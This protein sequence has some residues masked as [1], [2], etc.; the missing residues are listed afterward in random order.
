MK[1][2]LLPIFLLFA[3]CKVSAQ[4]S[5]VKQ[6]ENIYYIMNQNNQY[7]GTIN[8]T[9]NSQIIG[10]NSKIVIV[11]VNSNITVYNSLGYIVSTR[12]FDTT[13]TLNSISN[14]GF[15]LNTLKGSIEFDLNFNE[16]KGISY[17]SGS[18][19]I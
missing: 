13:V 10:S 9:P 2:I 17:G 11:K 14:E 6:V 4:I 16:I 5:G 15:E 8:V 3:S 12:T 19:G 7:T 1:S 18:F